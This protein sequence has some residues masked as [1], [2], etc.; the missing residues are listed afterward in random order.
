LLPTL[1]RIGGSSA[2][3][4]IQAAVA[5][6]DSRQHEPGMRA[7]CNWPE[8]S[9]APRLIELAKMEPHPEHREMALAALIRVAPL[10]DNRP[11]AER[12][13]LLQTVMLMCT[14]DEQRNLVLKRARAIRTVETLRFVLEYV[15]QP[16]H[17]EP[18][19]ETIVELAHHRELRDANKPEFHAALD[20][21]LATSKDATVLERATRYKKGQTWARPTP[22]SS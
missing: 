20:K 2:L 7:L 10:P 1:G 3:E 13:K 21:V 4:K 16:Q 6:D 11:A 19:C 15:D 14:R 18:A 22:A 8:A 17:A 9:I 12:L 5:S